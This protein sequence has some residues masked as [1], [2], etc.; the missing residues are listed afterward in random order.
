MTH[1]QNPG[2]SPLPRPLTQIAADALPSDAL[3][4]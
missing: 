3:G 4:R 1:D 2:G